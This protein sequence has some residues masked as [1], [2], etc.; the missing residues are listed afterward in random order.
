MRIE[1]FSAGCPLSFRVIERLR[2]RYPDADEVV[3][4]NIFEEESKRKADY[5]GVQQ[6]PAVVIDGQLIPLADI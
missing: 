5:Y 6:I 4:H 1:V 2:A 3:I